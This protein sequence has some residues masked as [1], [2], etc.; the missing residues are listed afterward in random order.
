MRC[1][2]IMRGDEKVFFGMEQR[3]TGDIRRR[4]KWEGGSSG[5]DSSIEGREEKPQGFF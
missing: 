5:R 3:E 2:Q 1:W 4:G